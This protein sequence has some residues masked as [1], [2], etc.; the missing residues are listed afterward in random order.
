MKCTGDVAPHSRIGKEYLTSTEIAIEINGFP[1]DCRVLVINGVCCSGRWTHI[2]SSVPQRMNAM[3]HAASPLDE[4][5]Y[6][7][8]SASDNLRCGLFVCALLHE[9]S[10]SPGG[11]IRSHVTRIREEIGMVGPGQQA[12]ASTARVSWRML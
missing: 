5:S 12:S 6:N 3:V 8:R 11:R 1:P 7:W 2:A 10:A 9:W 4:P